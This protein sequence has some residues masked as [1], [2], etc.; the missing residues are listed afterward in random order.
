VQKLQTLLRETKET[1]KIHDKQTTNE[2]TNN[3]Y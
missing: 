1:Q 2:R 3:G